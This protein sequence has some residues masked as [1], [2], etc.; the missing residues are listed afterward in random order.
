[1][2]NPSGN[3]YPQQHK[4]PIAPSATPII[5]S[6][7]KL[8]RRSLGLWWL[9]IGLGSVVLISSLCAA[10]VYAVG[11]A[12]TNTPAGN[13]PIAIRSTATITRTT[14]QPTATLARATAT[15]IRPVPTQPPASPAILTGAT[16]G[17]T[18][19]G[20][21]ARY[22]PADSSGSQN[23]S[24]SAITIAGQSVALDLS[25]D[26]GTDG[27]S[28]MVSAQASPANGGTWDTATAFA[29]MGALSPADSAFLR[30]DTSNANFD[31]RIEQSGQLAATLPASQFVNGANNPVPVGEFNV[32]CALNSGGQVMFCFL[33][34]GEP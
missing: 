16:I 29:V 2:D 19:A 34:P 31:T 23:A 8:S 9:P 27:Q 33:T 20:F 3:L 17:G 6:P 21:V 13:T 11:G 1:M 32:A 30:N 22:G 28:H 25:F 4:Q 18:Q 15:T 24:W 10:L 14:P 26:S 5:S 12:P 7:A